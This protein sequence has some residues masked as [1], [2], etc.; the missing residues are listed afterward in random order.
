[1][2]H[3]NDSDEVKCD[4]YISKYHNYIVIITF[5]HVIIITN[6]YSYHKV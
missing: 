5:H 4:S 2:L 6:L 1:M 3:N